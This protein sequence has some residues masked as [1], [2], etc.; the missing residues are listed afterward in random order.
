[1]G[2]SAFACLCSVPPSKGHTDES[3]ALGGEAA[4]GRGVRCFSGGVSHG[5]SPA[6]ARPVTRYMQGRVGVS[7][8]MYSV[9]E[10]QTLEE[11]AVE[12]EAGRE[13]RGLGLLGSEPCDLDQREG[14]D[15]PGHR[16]P[17]LAWRTFCVGMGS[18]PHP[19][20]WVCRAEVRCCSDPGGWLGLWAGGQ[21]R[22]GDSR[23][24]L[25][26]VRLTLCGSAV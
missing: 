18:G 24:L 16:V 3:S 5:A 11:A 10:F 2:A 6:G 13:G 19:C 22:G 4:A 1:M 9:L 17:A 7:S 8:C 14:G 21:S 25:G 12:P 15:R 20:L 26:S 23:G